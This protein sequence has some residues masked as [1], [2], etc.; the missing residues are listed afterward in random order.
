[1]PR[2]FLPSRLEGIEDIENYQ[3]GGFHPVSIGDCYAQQRYRVVHKLGY[4]GSSTVWLARDQTGPGRLVTLKVMRADASSGDALVI[5]EML[6]AALPA[7]VDIQTVDDH[8]VVQGPNGSHLFMVSPFAGPSILAMSDCP[9]RTSGSRRLRADLARKVAK[10]TATA[11]YHMHRAGVVHGDLTTSNILFALSP[12][13]LKWS[14]ADLYASLGEPETEKVRTRDGSPRPP[15]AP[16]ELVAPIDNSSLT[17]ASF[18]QERVVLCD[19]GQSYTAASPPQGYKPATV[20]NYLSPE[21]RFEARAGLEADVWALGC[22]V[23]EMRAGFPLF[24][25]FFGSD[26]DILTQTVEMLGRLPEPWWGAFVEEQARAGVWLKG[27]QSGIRERLREI[28][29]QDDAPAVGEGKM[30]EPFG[31]RLR[32]GEVELLGDLLEKMLKYRP[33]ERIKIDEVIRHPWFD[34]TD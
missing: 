19:F 14:D 9:G 33:E 8:F 29:A 17:N 20:F 32:E 16:A 13:V 34:F 5:P 21:A 27:A 10:Q 28:G 7:S 12:D 24:E 6:R 3:L 2:R 25:S 22:A 23:F 30:I 4:G 31:V 15:S 26:E 18:L 1:M 11:V